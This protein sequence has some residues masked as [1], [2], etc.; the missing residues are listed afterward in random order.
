MSLLNEESQER[1]SKYQELEDKL[2]SKKK[3][4][5]EQFTDLQR[6]EVF[7]LCKNYKSFLDKAK[8]EREAVREIELIAK[9]SGF[10]KMDDAKGHLESGAKLYDIYRNKNAALVIVGKK[11]ISDGVRIIIS[12]VDSPRLDLKPHP[13]YEDSELAMLKTHYYGGIKKHQWADR[14][15]SLHGVVL[16]KDGKN[17]EIVIGESQD[18]PVFVISDLAIHLSRNSQDKRSA[19]G[20]LKGEEMNIIAGNIPVKDEKVKQKVKLA[21]LEHL[22]DKY[23][24]VEED[25]ASA[26]IE[27]VPAEKARDI[28][29]DRAFVGAYGHDDKSGVFSSLSAACSVKQPEHTTIVLFIDKE[30]IG[31]LGNTSASAPYLEHVIARLSCLCGDGK[32]CKDVREILMESWAISLDVSNAVN[33]TFKNLHDVH[34]SFFAGFG[35]SFHMYT[36]AGGKYYSSHASCEYAGTMRKMFNDRKIPW[37]PGEDCKVDEGGGGT[38]AIHFSR[39]G[40]DVIDVNIP[41][42][43]IHSPFEVVSKADIFSAYLV[44]LAFLES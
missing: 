20:I 10:T 16:T 43:G 12:H 44:S 26:E 14:P 29:F 42:L 41:V 2:V 1:K 38:L 40:M 18:D 37:Q 6:K 32:Q 13:L 27:A 28:G 34:N 36:G 8:T 19:R 9:N 5:W 15:I 35:V 11:P 17:V 31:S 22:Y 30:E 3:S 7:S 4:A 33:P 24:I 23:G 21:V 39:Y 25:F